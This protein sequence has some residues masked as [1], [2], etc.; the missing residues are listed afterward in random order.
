MI[1]HA[2]TG[3]P[4]QYNK[5]RTAINGGSVGAVTSALSSCTTVPKS[6]T[7]DT[8]PQM[9]FEACFKERQPSHQKP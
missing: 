2:Y 1:I 5:V 3:K 9:L 6:R 7:P 8:L 4:Y